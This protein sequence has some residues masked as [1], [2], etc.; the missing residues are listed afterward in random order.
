MR[1]TT[2]TLTILIALAGCTTSGSIGELRDRDWSLVWIDGFPTLPSG[3][4][5]PTARFGSDGRFGGN[6][7]CNSAGANYTAEGDRLALDAM[8][9]TKRACIETAGNEL[10]RAYVSAMERARRFRIVNGQLELLDDGG[11]VLARFTASA[12]T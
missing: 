7:G 5:T 9:T 12:T 10:E 8:I 11:R 3:V 4:A 2:L 6:T 1:L